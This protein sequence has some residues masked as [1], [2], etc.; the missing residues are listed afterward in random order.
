MK[1]RTHSTWPTLIIAMSSNTGK[2]R[3]F[4]IFTLG[5]RMNNYLFNEDIYLCMRMERQD[6]RD[7]DVVGFPGILA[8]QV[9]ESFEKKL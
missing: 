2:K 3:I 8:E 4:N 9:I 1:H 5:A 7:Y 6:F